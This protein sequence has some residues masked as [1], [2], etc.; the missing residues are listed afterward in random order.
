MTK[1][2]CPYCKKQTELLRRGKTYP[3]PTRHSVLALL[4]ELE[5]GSERYTRQ[6]SART[7]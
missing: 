6:V 2:V 7:I 3:Q 4:E 1:A 5:T